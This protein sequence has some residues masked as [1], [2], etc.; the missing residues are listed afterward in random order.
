[1]GFQLKILRHQTGAGAHRRES[2]GQASDTELQR[3]SSRE[4][5]KPQ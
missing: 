4:H 1:M 5:N 3:L 2:S